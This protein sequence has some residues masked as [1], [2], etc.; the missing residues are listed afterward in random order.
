MAERDDFRLVGCQT[1]GDEWIESR[2]ADESLTRVRTDAEWISRSPDSFE[3]TLKIQHAVQEK[4][5]AILGT[6]HEGQSLVN[7][8]DEALKRISDIRMGI[9]HADEVFVGYDAL[10]MRIEQ[11]FQGLS[12]PPRRKPKMDDALFVFRKIR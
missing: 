5:G 10:A 4:Y 1:I 11:D 9:R 6:R 8:T 3:K 2:I 12:L 7:W